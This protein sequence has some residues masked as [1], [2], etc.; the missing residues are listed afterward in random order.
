MDTQKLDIPGHG[1]SARKPSF[2]QSSRLSEYS[3]ASGRNE[4]RPSQVGPWYIIMP[5]STFKMLWE[6]IGE[7]WACGRSS[8]CKNSVFLRFSLLDTSDWP[9]G[10]HDHGHA[11]QPI[12]FVELEHSMVC[13]GHRRLYPFRHRHNS[14]FLLGLRGRQWRPDKVMV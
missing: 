8:F 2:T 9:C 3:P 12:L 13:I 5:N 11:D 4:A 7:V 1:D 6:F 14:V 10:L